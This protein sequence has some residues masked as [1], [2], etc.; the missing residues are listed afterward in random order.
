MEVC[1]FRPNI[2][3]CTSTWS[4]STCSYQRAVKLLLYS[5]INPGLLSICSSN[6]VP[7]HI[8]V[9]TFILFFHMYFSKCVIGT[10]LDI[11]V[12]TIVSV[13]LFLVCAC[14]RVQCGW[15]PSRDV[16]ELAHRASHCLLSQF[17][18]QGIG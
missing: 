2:N 5:N 7:V 12:E 6:P 3:V 11:G 14:M 18:A 1:V 13:S 10:F 9:F 16:H 8:S 4:W 15:R 17:H